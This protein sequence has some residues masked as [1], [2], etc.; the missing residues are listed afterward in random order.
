V[1]ANIAKLAAESTSIT[2]REA[3]FRFQ[4]LM[5]R[6]DHALEEARSI[7]RTRLVENPESLDDA[8][9]PVRIKKFRFVREETKFAALISHLSDIHQQMISALNTIAT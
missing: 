8:T 9:I 2:D 3:S 4:Q 6:A 7:I 5:R 1:V